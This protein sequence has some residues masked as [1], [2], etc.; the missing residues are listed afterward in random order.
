MCVSGKSLN[1]FAPLA[2][3]G[4]AFLLVVNTHEIGLKPNLRKALG[5]W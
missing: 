3:A 4:G 1:L 5:W 2:P